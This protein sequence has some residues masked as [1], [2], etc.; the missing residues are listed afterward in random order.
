MKYLYI[1]TS[2]NFLY[3]GIVDND[4]LLI[5][6]SEKLEQNLS[7]NALPEIAK[8]F[9]EVNIKPNDIDKIIVVDGPGSFTGIRIGITIAKIYA[10]A[11]KK[12]ITTVSSLEVM[13]V[14][15]ENASYYVTLIDARRGFVYGAIYDSNYKEIFEKS[16]IKLEIIK[17]ELKKLDNYLII[18]NDEIDIEGKKVTYKP[19]I[20]KVVN[21]YK[22][23]KSI[24]PHTVN[25]NYLKLTEAEEKL[26][27]SK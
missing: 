20:L 15:N 26:L 10:Y 9:E 18:T 5:E 21:K 22:N 8:M 4:K 16:Y 17:N 13:A 6:Q 24:N 19:D 7:K 25:P 23:R 3:T 27:E 1:D 12:D 14:S 2:S 11:L